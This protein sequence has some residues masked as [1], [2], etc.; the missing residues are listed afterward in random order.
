MRLAAIGIACALLASAQETPQ[1]R[2]DVALVHVDVEVTD[3]T[4]TLDGFHKD[5]FAVKDKGA[6]QSILYFSQDE[7]PLDLILLFDVSGSMKTSVERV[8]ASAHTALAELRPGDRVAVMVFSGHS[9][10][11]APFTER[12]DQVE[13]DVNDVVMSRFGGSTHLLAAVDDA[14]KYF[15]A[16]PGAHRRRAVLILTD[17]YGQRSRRA[18]TVIHNL[19][20]ADASLSGL[21]IRS[22]ADVALNTSAMVMNP[23]LGLLL[24]EG[25]DGV[26]D[27]TGGDT[28]KAD[29]PGDAF[30]EMMRR[31]RRRYSLYYAMPAGKAGEARP[32]RV[33]LSND[34]RGRFPNARIRARKGYVTPIAPKS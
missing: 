32:V 34:A 5:D 27:Q 30:R 14:A 9:R 33:E 28:L 25:M 12:F 13:N 2:S 4:R 16:Q 17:N 29:D 11:I 6:P 8:A 22:G 21:I 19:W 20:E 15:L 24:R 3:G 10:L 26:A 18:S 7:E 31:I 23:A 1:F